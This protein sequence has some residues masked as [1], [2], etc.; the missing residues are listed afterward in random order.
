MNYKF[1][2]IGAGNMGGAL[3]QAV[4]KQIGGEKVYISCLTADETAQ[5]A[6]ALGCNA[7]DNQAIASDCDYIFLGVK[8]QMMEEMLSEISNTLKTR[9]GKFVLVSMAAGLSI[10][11][12]STFAGGNYPIIRIMPNTP[13]AVGNGMILACKNELVSDEQFADFKTAMAKSGKIDDLDEKLIDAGSAV[14]GCGPAFVYMFIEA[15]ADGGVECGLPRAK[16]LEYAAQTVLGSADMVIKSSRHPEELK[17][18]V[19]SPAGSTIMGV[20]ALEQNGFRAAAIEAVRAA[21]DR[22]KELGK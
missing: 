4:I 6:K 3:S 22:T 18:A 11:K 1:G 17:D 2:F 20:H 15:L 10:D 12:I 9:N 21:F 16:A 13:V 8:P 19:C 14:S 5:K 7:S